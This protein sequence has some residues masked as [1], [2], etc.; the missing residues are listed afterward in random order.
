M[1]LRIPTREPSK[2]WMHDTANCNVE[3]KYGWLDVVV[4]ANSLVTYTQA[5]VVTQNGY[6]S[7]VVLHLD[8]LDIASSVNL[9]SFAVAQTCKVS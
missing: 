6:E 5:Q 7:M 8:Q 4:G 1:T 9:Q 3:R 2:D